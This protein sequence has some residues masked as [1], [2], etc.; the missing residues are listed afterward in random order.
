MEYSAWLTKVLPTHR[1]AV[2]LLFFD[3]K[4]LSIKEIILN[5]FLPVNDLF[6]FK[7]LRTK[8]Y[9]QP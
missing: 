8:K 6:Y 7:P 2:Q 9:L 5:D 3:N 1:D 4:A